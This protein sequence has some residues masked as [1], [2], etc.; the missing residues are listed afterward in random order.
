M[1]YSHKC[2]TN[3]AQSICILAN[4]Y[5]GT[6]I[7]MNTLSIEKGEFVDSFLE[8]TIIFTIEFIWWCKGWVA[9]NKHF[10]GIS[11]LNIPFLA[12][13]LQHT[14]RIFRHTTSSEATS[15]L[16]HEGHTGFLVCACIIISVASILFWLCNG[17]KMWTFPVMETYMNRLPT[18]SITTYTTPKI[19]I[20]T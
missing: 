12:D 6:C 10:P 7:Y 1:Y 4:R 14:R 15:I 16:V 3:P 17:V 8:G 2:T 18:T 5:T 9:D 11:F 13:C 19:K 20:F